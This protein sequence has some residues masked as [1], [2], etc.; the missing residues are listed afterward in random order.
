MSN[1]RQAGTVSCIGAYDP[2]ALPVERARQIIR[3]TLQPI[4]AVEHVA[5]HDA[6]GRVLGADIVSPI[7]VPAHDNSAMDGYALHG[8][9]LLA[10]APTALKIVGT[11]FAGHA[12]EGTVAA[13]DC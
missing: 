10:G 13:G 4:H 9:D 2:N 3:Q 12:Y 11:A 5:I 6:L 7:Y 1:I 8:A